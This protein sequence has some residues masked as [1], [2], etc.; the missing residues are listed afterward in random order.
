LHFSPKGQLCLEGRTE[1]QRNPHRLGT[2][3]WGV[4]DHRPACRLDKLCSESPPGPMTMHHGLQR[5]AAIV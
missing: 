5:F 1:K 4:V 2:L 3:G